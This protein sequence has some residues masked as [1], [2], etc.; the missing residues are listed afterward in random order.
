M[1]F[2]VPTDIYVE[3]NCVINH[4]KELAALGKRALIVTG[5]YSARANGSLD[6]VIAVLDGEGIPYEIFDQ[7]EE[8]PSVETIVKAAEMGKAF[9]G[10]F[11]IGIGGGSPLDASKA[12]ALLMANP[13]KDG[14][15]L[16]QS[17]DL[18]HLPVASIPTTCGTGS[19]ATP[20][21]VLTNY[22]M[23]VKKSI[24]YKIFPALALVDGKYL[25]SAKRSLIV[26]T[27]VDALAHLVESYLN[28]KSNLFNRMASEYGLMLWAKTREILAKE[29]PLTEEDYEHLMFDATVAGMAIAH[30]A[31]GLPHGMSY[32]LTYNFGVPHGKACGYFL[33]AYMEMCSLHKP[34]EVQKILDFL[35]MKDLK[36]F[37]DEIRDLIG[38]YE[39]KAADKEKFM[40]AMQ[41]NQG[42]LAAAPWNVSPEE[43]CR[44]YD[45]SLITVD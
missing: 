36:E 16:Y 7:V 31:T 42:K 43:V 9:Q 33:A 14:S 20:V 8:N 22:Q 26:N 34:E 28:T 5:R 17:L 3:K 29:T 19:E 12:I 30:T 10:D 39:I 23:Q 41:T 32:D 15:C 1:R 4:G 11:V 21:S 13:D 45:L 27:A 25:A 44:I 37:A 35:G 38:T 2:Y 18:P 40:A 6:D 24:P